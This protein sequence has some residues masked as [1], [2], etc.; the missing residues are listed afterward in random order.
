MK[1]TLAIIC[2]FFLNYSFAQKT[3]LDKGLIAFDAKDFKKAIDKLKPYAEQGNCLAQFAV[4]FSYMYEPRIKNDSLARHWLEL[5][6]DQKQPKAM[7]PLSVNYFSAEEGSIVKAYM[8]AM[9]AAEY[10]PIQKMTSTRLVI[11]GYL[12][13][14]ELEQANKLINVYKERWGNAPDCR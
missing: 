14:E 11:K 10:D 1:Y 4:G 7:G 12:K 3:D 8:W 6:A 9:L 2:C 5:A 13:P